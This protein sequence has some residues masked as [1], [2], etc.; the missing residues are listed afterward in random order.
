[1]KSIKV[2]KEI[3]RGETAYGG[4][5]WG[6][7]RVFPNPQPPSQLA[8]LQH[9]EILVTS[10]LDPDH[11]PYLFDKDKEGKVL[12][13]KEGLTVSKVLGII[14]DEGGRLSH[15]AVVGREML[16]VPTIV[17]TS[18]ENATKHLKTG[19][20]VVLDA[21]QGRVYEYLGGGEAIDEKIAKWDVQ[22]T[23]FGL[24]MTVRNILILKAMALK[25]E[26]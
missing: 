1:M 8:A 15:G 11:N 16:R 4:K 20:V 24:R 7:V 22:Y 26:E 18:P 19:D 5:V 10:K 25:G 14:T 13:T 17:G 3:L 6:K 12:R 9:G 23:K 2:G 21:D